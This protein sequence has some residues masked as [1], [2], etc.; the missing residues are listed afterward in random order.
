VTI[1]MQFGVSRDA[2]VV[3]LGSQTVGK[4]SIV[5]RLIRG[6]F[7]VETVSTIGAVF[8]SKTVTVGDVQVKLQ[9]W[10]TGGSERYRSMAPMYFRDADAAIV[11]YDMT[12][13]QSFQELDGWLKALI[14]QGP[15]ALVVALVGNKCDLRGSRTVSPEMARGFLTD[16]GIPIYIEA[17]A[18]TGENVEAIFEK[19]ATAVLTGGTVL[20]PKKRGVSFD[21][22]KKEGG[23][24]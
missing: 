22:P 9:I 19:V 21:A 2:K 7:T 1:V 20:D 12:S 18:L 8:Q 4:S 10:D 11:V 16:N 14:E 24:C 6:T 5:T 15:E 3:M 17:S 13:T 23:C